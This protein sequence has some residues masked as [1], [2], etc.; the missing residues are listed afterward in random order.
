M[1][2][3]TPL[4][5]LIGGIT[6]MVV[7]C[8]SAPTPA[9]S[10]ANASTNANAS[11]P[12]SSLIAAPPTTAVVAGDTACAE[13]KFTSDQ[14]VGDWKEQDGTQ[15]MTLGPDG[16]LTSQGGGTPQSGTWSY[17]PW[18]DSP[19]KNEMPDSAATLCVLWLAI[20]NAAPALNLVYVPLK[21]T[22]TSLELSYVGRGNTVTWVRPTNSQ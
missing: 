17:A 19:A 13:T 20:T 21:L 1:K 2:K 22:D 14:F 15:V 16:T 8:T 10:T 4:G 18:K 6:V 11:T 7:G 3:W 5:C 9:P 12:S